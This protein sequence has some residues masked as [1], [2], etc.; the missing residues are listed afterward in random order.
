MEHVGHA[1]AIFL[2]QFTD[3]L[4]HPWQ[5]APRDGAVHAVVVRGNPPHRREGILAPGPEAHTLGFV[6]GQAH[7]TG[8]GL[9]EH[10]GHP[11]AVILDVG[12][13]TIQ[14][15]QE[16]GG[17]VHRVA[18]VDEILRGADR[19]VVHHLQATGDDAG[20]DDL[21]HGAAGVLDAIEAGQQNSRHLGF[22]QQF[23]GHFGNDAEHALGAG[24]QRQQVEARA[25][26]GV[27]AQGQAFA[28]DGE[29]FDLEQ[30]VHGQSVLQAVHATGVFGDVAADRAG[31][32]R[33]RVGCVVQAMGRGRLGNGQ[34]A[35]TGLHP[36]ETPLR[37]DFENAVEACHHQQDALGQWQ[38]TARQ[39]G[40]GAARH[41]RH[42]TQ[43]AEP[44]QRLHLFQAFGQ[45]HQ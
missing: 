23:D 40:P 31:D 2:A 24:E 11:R 20:G 37:V 8:T 36:G 42:A 39:A 18:G 43:V 29:D 35:Y 10:V 21:G 14:L 34:V 12:F 9:L 17:R 5:L 26:E 41:H 38:G 45:H 25:V 13:D 15:A 44:E 33:R 7:F 28:L 4:E 1:Q 27:A 32:L 6:A 19:Q 16:D 22:G 30:V 3:A